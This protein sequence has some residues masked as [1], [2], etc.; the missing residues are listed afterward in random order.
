M[1]TCGAEDR[2]EEERDHSAMHILAQCGVRAR[3]I[4]GRTEGEAK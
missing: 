2:E 1:R 4:S 3:T